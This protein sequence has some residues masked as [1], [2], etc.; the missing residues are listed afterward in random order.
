MAL[1]VVGFDSYFL[2][3]PTQCFFS[4]D[5]SSFIYSYSYSYDFYGLLNN[6]NLYGIKV[7]LI[8]GQLAAGVLMFVSCVM[9]IIIFAI[10]SYRVQKATVLQDGPPVPVAIIS[11]P[12]QYVPP[13]MNPT[14][15]KSLDENPVIQP[16]AI[17]PVA[18]PYNPPVDPPMSSV[19]AKNQLICPNCRTRFQVSTA[20]PAP[21]IPPAIRPLAQTYPSN[22]SS[23]IPVEPI[24]VQ[25]PVST[26]SL[27]IAQQLSDTIS[28]GTKLFEPGDVHCDSCTNSVFGRHCKTV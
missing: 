4:S 25:Q 13:Y 14:N 16:P 5:C 21:N 9:F 15:G 8:K 1:C 23:T 19:T 18:P 28:T 24:T 20:H 2:N 6:S 17:H 22:I 3:Y 7:P 27:N 10:T 12:V 11:P 26:T